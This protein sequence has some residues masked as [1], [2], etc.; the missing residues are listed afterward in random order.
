MDRWRVPGGGAGG[1]GEG[2]GALFGLLVFAM[3]CKSQESSS[4]DAS[5][6]LAY[7]K[8]IE[9]GDTLFIGLEDGWDGDTIPVQVVWAELDSTLRAELS[10]D[11]DSA[12]MILTANGSW[13][14]DST[15]QLC[16]MNVAQSWWKFRVLLVYDQDRKAFTRSESVALFYGGDGG[17]IATSSFLFDQDGDGDRDLVVRTRDRSLRMSEEGDVNEVIEESVY[18]RDWAVGGF[19]DSPMAVDT[20]AMVE[21]FGVEWE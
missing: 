17:Q 21:R 2:L 3:G 19:K 4:S 8:P 6:L 18:L 7:F 9:P 5:E 14:Q 11:P 20:V 16:L 10:P 13:M 1:F 12:A 15:H